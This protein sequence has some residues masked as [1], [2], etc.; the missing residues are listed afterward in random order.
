M[1]APLAKTNVVQ[2]PAQIKATAPQ[3]KPNS[4]AVSKPQNSYNAPVS[5]PQTA[6]NNKGI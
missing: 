1:S 5:K 4:A 2:T 6:Y 3:I